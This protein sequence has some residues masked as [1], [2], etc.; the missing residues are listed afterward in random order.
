MHAVIAPSLT[1]RRPARV[2]DTPGRVAGRLDSVTGLEER[3]AGDHPDGERGEPVGIPGVFGTRTEET[4]CKSGCGSAK[5]NL[6][7]VLTESQLEALQPQVGTYAELVLESRP[8]GQNATGCYL[9]WGRHDRQ[10][11]DGHPRHGRD[12]PSFL[13]ATRPRARVGT[14]FNRFHGRNR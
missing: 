10:D 5:R 2:A 11:R 12:V 9:E 6:G 4:L 7:K 3:A 14:P 13:L 1:T 8:S